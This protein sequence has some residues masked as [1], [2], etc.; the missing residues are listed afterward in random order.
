[1][2]YEKY[3]ISSRWFLPHSGGAKQEN[4]NKILPNQYSIKLSFSALLSLMKIGGNIRAVG[5]VKTQHIQFR[6]N[7]DKFKDDSNLKKTPLID[8]PSSQ[9]APRIILSYNPANE[10]KR[11]VRWIFAILL[12]CDTINMRNCENSKCSIKFPTH[13]R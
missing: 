7:A 4:K 5:C 3:K 9:G 12:K 6:T 11:C 1:M 10:I 13:I 8:L 2:S